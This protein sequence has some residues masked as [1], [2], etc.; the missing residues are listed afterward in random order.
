VLECRVLGLRGE[1]GQARV[2]AV[3]SMIDKAALVRSDRSRHR[4]TFRVTLFSP[5]TGVQPKRPRR[6][7]PLRLAASRRVARV[8]DFA[9]KGSVRMRSP[10]YST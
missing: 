9:L 10:R 5:F 4:I 8:L 1:D 7:G 2:G 6:A 3:Q